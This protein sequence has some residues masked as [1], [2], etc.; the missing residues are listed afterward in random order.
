MDKQLERCLAWALKDLS[1]H[2]AWAV[3]EEVESF[4]RR[5]RNKAKLELINHVQDS[6]KEINDFYK[7]LPYASAVLKEQG[8][9]STEDLVKSWKDI[10]INRIIKESG[11]AEDAGINKQ[12]ESFDPDHDCPKCGGELDVE[13]RICGDCGSFDEGRGDILADMR[14]GK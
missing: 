7:S 3:K 4:L 9:N 1:E 14:T 6:A 5:E 10:L 12:G 13:Y 8:R 2:E 11:S